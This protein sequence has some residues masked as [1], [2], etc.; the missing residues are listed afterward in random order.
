M[1]GERALLLVAP[2]RSIAQIESVSEAQSGDASGSRTNIAGWSGGSGLTLLGRKAGDGMR[3]IEVWLYWSFAVCII[4]VQ[5]RLT[6]GHPLLGGGG[7]VKPRTL[8]HRR[9][10]A[11]AAPLHDPSRAL[12]DEGCGR[13]GATMASPL[14]NGLFNKKSQS[15]THPSAGASSSSGSPLEGFLKRLFPT[16]DYLERLAAP[17]QPDGSQRASY[18]CKAPAQENKPPKKINKPQSPAPSASQR[19]REQVIAPSQPTRL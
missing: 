17:T 5:L 8:W 1:L 4:G 10:R 18:Y 16:G 13:R 2:R 3:P 7:R 9:Q 12:F 11:G 6:L 15:I 14:I 19:K